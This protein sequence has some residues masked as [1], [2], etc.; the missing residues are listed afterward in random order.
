MAERHI[1]A[2]SFTDEQHKILF[3]A[4]QL[5]SRAMSQIIRIGAL[6]EAKAIIKRL[7]R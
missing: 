5:D 3:K 6:R 4:G 2:I 1:V 7:S